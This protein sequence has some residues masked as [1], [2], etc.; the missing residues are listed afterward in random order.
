MFAPSMSPG[1]TGLH[2]VQGEGSAFANEWREM[3]TEIT[4]KPKVAN[5]KAV[6]ARPARQEQ[7]AKLLRRKS[8]ATIAQLQKAFS[9]KPHTARAAIS[10]LRK[11]GTQIERTD[12]DKGAVYCAVKQG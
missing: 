7:L 4:Q 10:A 3:M 8:G 1:M 11:G 9:W 2:S 12:T 6:K 5:A